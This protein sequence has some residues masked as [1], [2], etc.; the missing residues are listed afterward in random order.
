LWEIPIAYVLATRFGM[1]PQGVA[2][3]VTIAFSTLAV[4]SIVLFRR[5]R[6]KTKTV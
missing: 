3:A 2:W 6:W 1:G 5:G 4:A